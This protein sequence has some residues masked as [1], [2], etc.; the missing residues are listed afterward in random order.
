MTKEEE[1]LN[2]LSKNVFDPILSSPKAS[3]ALKKGVRYTIMRLKNLSAESRV[4]YYWSAIGGTERSTE[5][6]RQMKKEGFTRFEEIIDEFRDKFNDAW[7]R[8]KE[9]RD[10]KSKKG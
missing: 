10:G 6:A 7:F 1:V 3:E 4:E 5:F 2:Y 8:L 9:V